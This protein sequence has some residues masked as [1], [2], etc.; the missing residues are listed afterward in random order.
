M[1][2]A[3]VSC[4]SES[5][6]RGKLTNEKTNERPKER[7]SVRTKIA[8]RSEASRTILFLLI[9]TALF[10]FLPQMVKGDI[11]Q[12]A[13]AIFFVE[14]VPNRKQIVTLRGS[15]RGSYLENLPQQGQIMTRISKICH[16][17]S[18]FLFKI[19]PNPPQILPNPSQNQFKIAPEGILEPI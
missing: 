4:Q 2:F 18:K 10:S 15:A 17:S 5:S 11:V 14:E 8:R 19:L 1:R 13:T 16:K 12:F 9:S 3:E 6:S 7:T